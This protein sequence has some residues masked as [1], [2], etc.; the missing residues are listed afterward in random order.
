[1]VE[2]NSRLDQQEIEIVNMNTGQKK[3]SGMKYRKAKEWKI[4][5]SV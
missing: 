2:S 1:M 4:K 3:V 5:K